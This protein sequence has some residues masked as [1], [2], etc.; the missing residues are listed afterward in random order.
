MRRIWAGMM[1]VGAIAVGSLSPARLQAAPTPAA[2]AKGKVAFQVCA[3]CHSDQPGVRRVGPSL[4]G[5]F[6]KPAGQMAGFPYSAGLASSKLRWD[7]KTLGAFIAKPKAV[8][9]GTTMTYAG[10]SDPAKRQS[11]IDYLESLQ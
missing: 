6:G 9:P 4:A 2:I 1:I 8:V 3:A 7:R 11:I 10:V 5:M